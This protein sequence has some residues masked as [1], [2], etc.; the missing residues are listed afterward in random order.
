MTMKALFKILY[1]VLRRDL[2]KLISIPTTE[3]PETDISRSGIEP[4]PPQSE[5]STL[6]KSYSNIYKYLLGWNII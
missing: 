6:A 2:T 1:A 3:Q 4:G 5:A